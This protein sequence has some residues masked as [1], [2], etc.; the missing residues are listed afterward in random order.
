MS[1]EGGGFAIAWDLLVVV[2]GLLG[3]TALRAAFHS[4]WLI[5]LGA[6]ALGGTA[7]LLSYVLNRMKIQRGVST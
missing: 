5:A 3:A 4:Y 2:A 6:V 1:R 7:G